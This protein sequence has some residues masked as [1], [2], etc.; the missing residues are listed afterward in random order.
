MSQINKDGVKVLPSASKEKDKTAWPKIDFSGGGYM[1]TK[2]NNDLRTLEGY[3]DLWWSHDGSEWTRV[4]YEEGTARDSNLYST[5]KWALTLDENN[6]FVNL[7]KW[8][9]T[10]ESFSVEE[11][12]NLDGDISNSTIAFEFCAGFMQDVKR[13]KIVE[14]KED[15]VP[16]LF[17]IAGDTTHGGPIVNDVFVSR[18]GGENFVFSF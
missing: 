3:V 9:H 17:V 14:A 13:C 6:Q 7:G 1:G 11:D 4:D 5:N 8:G 12:L 16:A 18:P 2:G 15:I 10:L